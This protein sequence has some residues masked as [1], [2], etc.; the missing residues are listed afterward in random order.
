[1]VVPSH[2]YFGTPV[3]R[4]IFLIHGFNLSENQNRLL[5]FPISDKP[6][7]LHV[8]LY[9][10]LYYCIYIYVYSTWSQY[11]PLFIIPIY[12][13][14]KNIPVYLHPISAIPSL[15]SILRLRTSFGSGR[16][17]LGSLATHAAWLLRCDRVTGD[18]VTGAAL[19]GRWKLRL[20]KESNLG[21]L[22]ELNEIFPKS[23][24]VW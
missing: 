24:R 17:I 2:H 1:M 3:L 18:R 21:P 9:Y 12:Q 10:T 22:G 7:C 13:G 20:R 6:F 5:V 23:G 11:I 14:I 19:H 8:W 16:H 4:Q 15:L